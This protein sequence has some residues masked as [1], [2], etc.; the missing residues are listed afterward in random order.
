MVVCQTYQIIKAYAIEL[1]QFDG[2]LQ[3]KFS[4]AGFIITI[5]TL[6]R[7]QN[8]RYFFLY[9]VTIFSQITHAFIHT[10]TSKRE[11]FTFV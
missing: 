6:V 2:V 1:S 5:Y 8:S 3:G 10:I 7:S 4:F 11:Y 9:K